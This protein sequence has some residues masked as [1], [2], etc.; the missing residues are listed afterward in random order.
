MTETAA[1]LRLV[2]RGETAEMLHVLFDADQQSNEKL[3]IYFTMRYEDQLAK[4]HRPQL[5]DKK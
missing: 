2:L 4:V 1:A 3:L 5:K